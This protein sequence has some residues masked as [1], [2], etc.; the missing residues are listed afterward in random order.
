MLIHRKHRLHSAH[1]IILHALCC[2]EQ[3]HLPNGEQCQHEAAFKEPC[4]AVNVLEEDVVTGE[5]GES[6][7]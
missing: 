4:C 5:K 7:N 2:L 6:I 1:S 3:G